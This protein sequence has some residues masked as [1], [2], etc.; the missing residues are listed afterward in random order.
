MI[1]T[2]PLHQMIG[3]GPVA[4]A[5]EHGAGNAAA[6]HP[7]KCFL[8]SFRLPVSN[9]FLALRETANV[10]ASF[11]CGAT[12]KTLQV[13]RVSFLDAFHCSACSS[14]KSQ[15]SSLLEASY[16][17]NRVKTITK[18]FVLVVALLFSVGIGEKATNAALGVANSLIA[19][20][21]LQEDGWTALKTHEG[22]LF[23][24]NLRGLYFTLSL[25][26]KE[27]KPIDDPDHIFFN[28]DGR[29]LQ[30]QL[31]SINDFAPEAKQKKLDD[32]SI[33]AT[34]RDW[35]AKFIEG[36]IKSKLTVQT[37]NAKLSDG[38]E[39]LMW[40]FDMPEGMNVE[41]KKQLYVTVVKNDYVL[42]LNS[43]ATAAITDSDGRKYLLDTLSTFKPSPTPIDLKQLSESL[44][45]GVGP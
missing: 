2:V 33:L 38:S 22:V 24:W 10:Q 23:V 11:V 25:K 21:P 36:L 6:Q 27:I 9:N 44:R 19:V 8:I 20:R 4:M 26:G 29:I 39:A 31:A 3:C 1:E 45:K 34:H 37:F 40:Q 30:I 15:V 28:V 32:K 12:A 14:F 7:R 35:E 17:A 42:M 5:V 18:S 13:G 43:V 41:A 16:N